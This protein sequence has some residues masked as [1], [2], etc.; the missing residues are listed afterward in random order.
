MYIYS[1]VSL[2]STADYK[3]VLC[4]VRVFRLLWDQVLNL[5]DSPEQQFNVY[6][7]HF[8]K[9]IYKTEQSSEII[10]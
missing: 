3:S 9:Y 2:H 6:Q 7:P 1:Q 5:L 4:I 10:Y 8:V